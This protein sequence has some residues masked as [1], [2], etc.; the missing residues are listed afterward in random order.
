MKILQR[1]TSDN[2]GP[3]EGQSTVNLERICEGIARITSD[4]VDPC[5]W[6]IDGQLEKGSAKKL[7]GLSLTMLILG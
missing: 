7:Q 6:L 1:I 4:N 5:R 3:G 2:V